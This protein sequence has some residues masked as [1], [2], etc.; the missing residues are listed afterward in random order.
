MKN[1]STFQPS[2]E[3]RRNNFLTHHADAKGVFRFVS[4]VVRLRLDESIHFAVVL[5]FSAS[6][7]ENWNVN[8]NFLAPT[9]RMENPGVSSMNIPDW[10]SVVGEALGAL[11]IEPLF[12]V[13]S[14]IFTFLIIHLESEIHSQQILINMCINFLKC[15][16]ER[17]SWQD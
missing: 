2:V 6:T 1:H 13:F 5:S 14:S 3:F 17:N 15:F 16:H 8:R 9:E 12:I 4:G 10:K 11:N 7:I